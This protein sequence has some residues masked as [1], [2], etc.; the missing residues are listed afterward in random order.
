MRGCGR[1]APCAQVNDEDRET[2]AGLQAAVFAPWVERIAAEAAAAGEAAP[3]A[4]DPPSVSLLD[5]ELEPVLLSKA[6][7][8]GL[9]A[10]WVARLARLDNQ[11]RQVSTLFSASCHTNIIV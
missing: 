4:W 7:Q 5:M 2:C 6:A 1:G 9:P 3:P 10:Q 8:L 11:R